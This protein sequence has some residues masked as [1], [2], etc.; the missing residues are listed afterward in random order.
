MTQAN[1]VQEIEEFIPRKDVPTYLS[2]AVDAVRNVGNFAA[3][4][5]KDTNTVEIVD[6]EQGEAERLLDVLESLFDF[7]F[8]QTKRLE[9]R[10][11]ALNAKL[12]SLGKPPMQG[13]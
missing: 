7:V 11:K 13:P 9:E 3:H 6:V 1:L 5:S 10:K 12:T 8:V 2:D 4:P